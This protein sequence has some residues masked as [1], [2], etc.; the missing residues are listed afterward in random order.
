MLLA[1]DEPLMDRLT[2]NTPSLGRDTKAC[3]ESQPWLPKLLSQNSAAEDGRVL[4]MIGITTTGFEL[5]PGL[6]CHEL[7]N[8]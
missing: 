5:M 4:V 6:Q 8:S 1:T 7:G 2:A 3:L